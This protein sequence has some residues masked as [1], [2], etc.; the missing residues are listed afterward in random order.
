MRRLAYWIREAFSNIQVNRTTTFVAI[1]TTA[2]T[3][4][5][6]GVYLLLYFNLRDVI[7]SLQEDIRIVI[8][9]DDTLTAQGVSELEQR[10]RSER[11]VASFTY[12]SK[13]QALA[14]FRKQFPAEERLL[15][16][17]GDNPLP[18]SLVVAISPQYRSTDSVR[19]WADRLKTVPGVTHIEYSQDW[20]ENISTI[21]RYFE[22]AAVVVGT[23]LMIASVAIIASTIRLTLY[24]RRDEIEIMRLIGATSLFIKIP[25]I[26]EGAVLGAIGGA[27]SLALLKSGFELV[28]AHWGVPGAVLGI[29]ASMEFFPV[30]VAGLVVVAGLVLGCTGS[31]VSLVELKK[32]RA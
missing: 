28:K 16:G 30:H 12:V 32:A 29:R 10:L 27:V 24:A 31:L 18:S 11:Q 21:I 14:D 20:I 1:A 7:A 3:L 13:D 22:L 26:L 17:L 19:R 15:E 5:C 9:L 25:Y 6:F 23:V 4:A 8:Y 2:F